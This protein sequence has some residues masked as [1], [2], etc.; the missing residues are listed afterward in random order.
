MLLTKAWLSGRLTFKSNTRFS[1]RRESFILS[2][3]EEEEFTDVLKH[4]SLVYAIMSGSVEPLR[5]LASNTLTTY[6]EYAL[7]HVFKAGSIDS[8]PTAD[9][10]SS[11]KDLVAKAKAANTQK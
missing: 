2:A 5:K 9:N 6:E 10:I 11:W 3:I 7:P 1:R 4:R 8:K